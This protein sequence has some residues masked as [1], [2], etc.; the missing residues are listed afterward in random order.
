MHAMVNTAVKAARLA[1]TIIL[2]AYDDKNRLNIT[3]KGINDYVTQVDK[4]AEQAIIKILQEAYPDHSILAEESGKHTPSH[5]TTSTHQWI[6][7]PLDGTLNFI[8]NFGHFCVSIALKVNDT[9]E[10]SVIYDPIRNEL[11]TASKGSGATL[12]SRRIRVNKKEHIQDSFLGTGYSVRNPENLDKNLK[13]FNSILKKV[14]DVR[15]TGSAALDLAYVAAGRL[16]AFYESDLMPWDLA[17]GSL[18]VLEAGGYVGDYSG[19]ESYLNKGEVIAGNIKIYKNLLQE[20]NK[21]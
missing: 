10:H 12:D 16:D 11:F 14:S 2:R 7:D 13:I 18:L 15:V 1:G 4:A 5:K 8:N 19:G 9:V 3:S 21:V 17:A 6:I 20:I